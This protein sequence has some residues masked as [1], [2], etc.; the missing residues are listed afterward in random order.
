M[1]YLG[2]SCQVIERVKIKTHN[3]YAHTFNLCDYVLVL[4]LVLDSFIEICVTCASNENFKIRQ[5]LRALF[6]KEA[7]SI[8][9]KHISAKHN[10]KEK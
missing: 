2:I 5:W 9:W 10:L 1:F 8:G 7:H 4:V 3:A 6:C